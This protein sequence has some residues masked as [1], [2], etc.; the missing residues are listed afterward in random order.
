MLVQMSHMSNSQVGN[1]CGSGPQMGT[2]FGGIDDPYI[3]LNVHIYW[4]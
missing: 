1:P 2:E 3:T 4:L